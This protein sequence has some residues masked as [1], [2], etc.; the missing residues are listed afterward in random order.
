MI[1]VKSGCL[2]HESQS[3]NK[4]FWEEESLH[5]EVLVLIF[6]A[7]IR[8]YITLT[9]CFCIGFLSTSGRPIFVSL[10]LLH[11]LP[12]LVMNLIS[13][14]RTNCVFITTWVSAPPAR[15]GQPHSSQKQTH[16]MYLGWFNF[17]SCSVMVQ[18]MS[19][20]AFC[21]Q[22]FLQLLTCFFQVW[23]AS[24]ECNALCKACH[25]GMQWKWT[26]SD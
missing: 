17:S 10:F 7:K 24:S 3:C 25:W 23:H 4:P 13:W 12:H 16:C 26:Q 21:S 5:L 2:L 22:L 6:Y 14:R 20:F 1:S 9:S 19:L 11:P 18:F 8:V 15:A